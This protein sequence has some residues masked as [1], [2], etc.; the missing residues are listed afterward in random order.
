[1]L[2]DRLS[3]LDQSLQKSNAD[4]AVKWR[5]RVEMLDARFDAVS[6]YLKE[7][8]TKVDVCIATRVEEVQQIESRLV[9]AIEILREGVVTKAET[10]DIR[11]GLW[12]K[13][14]KTD[15]PGMPASASMTQGM[16]P[17]GGDMTL[18]RA[19]TAASALNTPSGRNRS[20]S[21]LAAS[22]AEH[23]GAREALA[24]ALSVEDMQIQMTDARPIP[25]RE[26]LEPPSGRTVTAAER[27]WMKQSD[28]GND[29]VE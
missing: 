5:Q 11:R 12:T 18:L 6:G 16:D 2:V 19:P 15:L 25:D 24:R 26:I 28:W 10:P 20:V 21:G 1:A 3:E 8:R 29:Y 17:F 9:R 27:A 22:S 7:M 4:W 13:V 23:D 14:D